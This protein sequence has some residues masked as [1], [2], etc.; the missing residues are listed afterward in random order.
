VLRGKYI[1]MNAY[2][3]KADI[4]NKQLNY[5]LYASRTTITNQ[6]KTSRWREIIR[7]KKINEVETKKFI[8]KEISKT[9]CL[10]FVKINS[11]NKPFSNLTR[12]KGKDRN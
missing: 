7:T 10:F 9:K 8:Y 1:A 5:A 12:Q 3:N 6:P 11:I 4:S 2:I